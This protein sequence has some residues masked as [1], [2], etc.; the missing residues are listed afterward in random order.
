M[1]FEGARLIVGDA[2]AP[3]ENSALLVEGDW[4]VRVGR[5]GEIDAPSGA[6]LVDLTGKTLMPALV[7]THVHVGLLKGLSFG[8]ENYNR[9]VLIDH[10]NRYAYYG[11]GTV[12]TAGTDVGPRS[13]EV[14]AERTPGA[15]RLLTSG[16]GMAAPNAG[17]G[18]RRLP[19]PRTRFRALTRGARPSRRWPRAAPTR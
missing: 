10:L 1:L 2:S 8:P 13:F 5:R 14:R 12:L 16:R 15:A 17:P 19:A 4:V 7:S 6:A 11:V 18:F 3:I 9:E